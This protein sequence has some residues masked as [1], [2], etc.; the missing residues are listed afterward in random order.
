ML[1]VLESAT[2]VPSLVEATV[3]D[4]RDQ[5]ARAVAAMYENQ[6]RDEYVWVRDFDP[7]QQ[8]VFFEH[9]AATWQQTYT[10]DDTDQTVTLTGPRIEV[11]PVTTY[12]PV[13][14]AGPVGESA[15]TPTTKEKPME[16]TEARMAELTADADRVT[17]LEADLASAIQRAEAAEADALQRTRDAYD[18]QVEAALS[19]SDLPAPAVERARAQLTLA[20][21]VAVPADPDSHIAAVVK[22]EADY[23]T[24][25]GATSRKGLGYGHAKP[26]S[27]ESYT[28]PWGRTITTK[29]A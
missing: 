9:Q 2:S 20:E 21:G 27:I 24:Q 18:V 14:S 3:Q 19:A 7:D 15:P 4:R 1:Q 25:I 29:E 8:L 11:R 16:I 22:A 23:L 5:L 28:N 13:T 26:A 10:V 6:G 17:A 12:H